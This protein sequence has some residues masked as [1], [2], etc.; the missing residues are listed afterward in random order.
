M[1]RELVLSSGWPM[2][3]RHNPLPLVQRAMLGMPVQ[4]PVRLV[5]C[6][7]VC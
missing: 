6:Q 4:V 7:T 5:A 2:N 1:T 3:A